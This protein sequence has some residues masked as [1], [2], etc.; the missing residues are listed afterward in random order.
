MK[1]IKVTILI[2]VLSTNLMLGQQNDTPIIKNRCFSNQPEKA[3]TVD[4]RILQ[5][6]PNFAQM[7]IED[8]N[9]VLM[10]D[11]VETG[12]FFRLVAF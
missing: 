11:N 6:Q 10:A 7:I 4:L 12:A 8:C 2:L 1:F 5:T 9:Q 3:N